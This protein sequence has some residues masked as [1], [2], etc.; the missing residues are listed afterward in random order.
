VARQSDRTMAW[1]DDAS[2]LAQGDRII[3]NRGAGN[4]IVRTIAEIVTDA[5]PDLDRIDF[6]P[7]PPVIPATYPVGTPLQLVK[8]TGAVFGFAGELAFSDGV[9]LVVDDDGFGASFLW[10][11]EGAND[12]AYLGAALATDP[13]DGTTRVIAGA[14][15]WHNNDGLERAGAVLVLNGGS[16]L[17]D[18]DGDPVIMT[19]SSNLYEGDVEELGLGRR[20][21]SGEVRS[22]GSFDIVA[23]ASA[24]LDS[25][26]LQENA[27]GALFVIPSGQSDIT[28]SGL[29]AVPHLYGAQAS[30]DGEGYD[31][32]FGASIAV[33]D[34]DGDGLDDILATAPS[35]VNVNQ[36]AVVIWGRSSLPTVLPVDMT[37]AHHA[38]TQILNVPTAVGNV[39]HTALIYAADGCGWVDV[40]S[41]QVPDLLLLGRTGSDFQAMMVAGRE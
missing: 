11:P 10:A 1:V 38:S 41:D 14:P 5:D 18:E 31:Y 27:Q 34:F 13:T 24:N 30:D 9:D 21:A 37:L 6:D 4:Q 39:A 17:A 28:G 29:S 22:A 35:D 40:N 12:M 23:S 3:I 8:A 26:Q 33:G 20:V 7:N 36:R 19:S 15:G 16:G 2:G 25:D 32:N